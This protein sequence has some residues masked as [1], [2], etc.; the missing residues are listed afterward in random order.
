VVALNP[1]HPTTRDWRSKA[2][3]LPLDRLRI[4]SLE[5]EEWHKHRLLESDAVDGVLREYFEDR[6]YVDTTIVAG[7]RVKALNAQLQ[8][9][10]EE[11]WHTRLKRIYEVHV[12]DR[13]GRVETRFVLA[14][15]TGWGWLAYRAFIAGQHLAKYVPPILG[16]R[17]GL[18]FTEWRLPDDGPQPP[19]REVTVTTLASYVAARVTGL[20]LEGDP[21]SELSRDNQHEGV[22]ELAGLLSA[23]Y[24]SKAA[25]L[26]RRRVREEL[27]RQL[28][29]SRQTLS[30]TARESENSMWSTPPTTWRMPFFISGSRRTKSGRSSHATSRSLVTPRWSSDCFSTSCS[31]ERG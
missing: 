12:R 8:G 23:A 7:D 9:L 15:S 19:R 4:L 5:P 26:K 16:L 18:L 24:G 30:T 28:P 6:G 25:A 22:D 1:V 14:K 2:E 27:T 10:S 21:S 20:S 31:R 13:A 29:S 17:H 3:C 11:K